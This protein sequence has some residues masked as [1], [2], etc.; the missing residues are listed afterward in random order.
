M[1]DFLQKLFEFI[2]EFWPFSIIHSYEQ[3]VK[4]RFGDDIAELNHGVWFRWPFLE[5]IHEVSVAEQTKNLLTQSLTTA[6]NESISFSVNIVYKIGSAR[7]M[8][9][10]VH[11]FD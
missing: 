9:V 7:K 6:D 2:R 11:D 5:E 3:G 1:G 4:F 8:Y 10:S